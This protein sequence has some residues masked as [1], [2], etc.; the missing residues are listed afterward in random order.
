MPLCVAGM[1]RSGTSM[2]V[3]LLNLC[4]LHL[5]P[6]KD[7][8]PP[9]PDNPEGFW[10]NRAFVRLND[11]VLKQRGGKWDQPPPDDLGWETEPSLDRLHAKAR[12]LVRRF[13]G[14]QP[15]GW[16]DPRNCLT[17]PFWQQVLPGMKVLI[18]VRHPAAVAESLWAR[19]GL[20]CAQSFDLWLTYNRRV[21]AV[22][23]PDD[24][25]VTHY[26]SYFHDPRAE[27][28]RVLGLL[29]IGATPGLLDQACATVN[30]SLVHHRTTEDDLVAAGGS[31]EL[32][33]CYRALCTEAG[34]PC[35]VPLGLSCER[36]AG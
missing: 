34:I 21:Q 36:Q 7:L 13:R 2:I 24:R 15:W 26:D 29:G 9:A 12:R 8:L 28:R 25:V 14:R 18:C 11:A 30:P 33:D 31:A 23:P 4:G 20:S 19:N 17:L 1:H 6:D 10:E 5:G 32:V 16:K 27:L 22:V 3:R 35:A